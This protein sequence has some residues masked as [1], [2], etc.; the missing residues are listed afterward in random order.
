VGIKIGEVNSLSA[1]FKT[2]WHNRGTFL[3]LPKSKDS[4]TLW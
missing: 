3:K 1:F 2:K 4:V